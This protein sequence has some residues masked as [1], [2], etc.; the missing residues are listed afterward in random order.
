MKVKICPKCDNSDLIMVAGGE[1]GLWEC[2]KC[3]FRGSL[4]P[5]KEIIFKKKTKRRISKKI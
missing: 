1:F 3:G 2:K 4:F 5:E